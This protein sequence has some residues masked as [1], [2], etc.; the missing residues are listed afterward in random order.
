MTKMPKASLTLDAA[1]IALYN[2]ALQVQL[3]T[4]MGPRELAAALAKLKPKPRKVKLKLGAQTWGHVTLADGREFLTSAYD[5][6]TLAATGAAHGETAQ[7]RARMEDSGDQSNY[8][9]NGRTTF[10]EFAARA[11]LNPAVIPVAIFKVVLLETDAEIERVRDHCFR[12]RGARQG[13]LT[14]WL[15][16]N[17]PAPEAIAA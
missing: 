13:W 14:G 1:G 3:E 9:E 15:V 2:D 17:T 16:D 11:F 8:G 7:Y 4:G 10:A 6:G 5:R 12:Q